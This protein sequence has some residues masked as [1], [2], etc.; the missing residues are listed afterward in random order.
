MVAQPIIG[1]LELYVAPMYNWIELRGRE[2]LSAFTRFLRAATVKSVLDIYVTNCE[3]I[4][5]LRV[6]ASSARATVAVF[7]DNLTT[8]GRSRGE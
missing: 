2:P 8:F 1:H 7:F 6:R 5:C 4:H 3:S